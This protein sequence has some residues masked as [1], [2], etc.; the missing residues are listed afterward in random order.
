MSNE[1][2]LDLLK[3]PLHVFDHQGRLAYLRISNH[4]NLQHNAVTC[5]RMASSIIW[6]RTCYDHCLL[7]Q[8]PGRFLSLKRHSLGPLRFSASQLLV[9][10]ELC[11]EGKYRMSMLGQYALTAAGISSLLKVGRLCDVAD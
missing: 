9:R 5:K 3:A 11:T 4:A 6:S 8:I 10:V 1:M 2:A 7:R